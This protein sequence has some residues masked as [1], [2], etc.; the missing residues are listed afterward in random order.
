M[1]VEPSSPTKGSIESSKK[2]KPL[3]K[4]PVKEVKA[5]VKREAVSDDD[6]KP[7]VSLIP[8]IIK[9][10]IKGEKSLIFIV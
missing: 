3:S 10:K 1:K 6:E 2:D 9:N 5:E 4:S 8:V 7:L